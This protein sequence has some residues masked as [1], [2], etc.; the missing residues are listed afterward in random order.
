MPDCDRSEDFTS[1]SAQGH[2]RLSA[3]TA[4]GGGVGH[5]TPRR[6]GQWSPRAPKHVVFPAQC[7]ANGGAV[8]G[9]LLWY[10]PTISDSAC[11]T[12]RQEVFR[13][14]AHQ[15]R[16]TN[17]C[18]TKQS[19][20]SPCRRTWSLF[21]TSAHGR[22]VPCAISSPYMCV[23]TFSKTV[24]ASLLRKTTAH[25]RLTCVVAKPSRCHAQCAVSSRDPS[26][27]RR[28]AQSQSPHHSVSNSTQRRGKRCAVA[29]RIAS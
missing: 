1:S 3:R 4:P 9:A 10:P 29:C 11:A 20:T 22:T 6:R 25:G 14:R 7:V 19:P 28:L 17:C 2:V 26:S 16:C 21:F 27:A 23:S 15:R 8:A 24:Q 18:V 12:H 5:P 13:R